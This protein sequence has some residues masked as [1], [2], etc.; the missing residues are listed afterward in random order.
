MSPASGDRAEEAEAVV[1]RRVSI[2]LMS[3]ASGDLRND[4]V[5]RVNGNRVSIQL[6][7][8]ASGDT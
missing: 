5:V 8:P 7:S 4:F 2:Q 3:P 6:M 1:K